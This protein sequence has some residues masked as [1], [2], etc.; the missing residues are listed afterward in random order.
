MKETKAENWSDLVTFIFLLFGGWFIRVLI[1]PAPA[2][3]TL[4]AFIINTSLRILLFLLPCLWL[5]AAMKIK[6]RELF[7]LHMAKEI[8][9]LLAIL[10][11]LAIIV[12][13]ILTNHQFRVNSNI[14]F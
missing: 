14:V 11:A 12:F 2:T 9:W 3:T 5:A 7:V 6:I 1:L 13:A 10:Y 4:T 8:G